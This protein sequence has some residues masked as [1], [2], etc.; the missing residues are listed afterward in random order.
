MRTVISRAMTKCENGA[1]RSIMLA[2][3]KTAFLYGDARRSLY[4]ELPPEDPCQLL[5]DTWKDLNV[6]CVELQTP[7]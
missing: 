7:R 2:D 4:V 3:A 6:P 5:V 1:K